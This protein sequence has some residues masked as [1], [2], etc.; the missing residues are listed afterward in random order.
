MD[1]T[2]GDEVQTYCAKN[3]I[4]WTFIVKLSPWIGGFYE[5]VVGLT[6]KIT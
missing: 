3:G 1:V 2:K 6:K 4:K 5:R